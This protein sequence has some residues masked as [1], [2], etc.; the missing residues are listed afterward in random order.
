MKILLIDDDEDLR[1]AIGIALKAGGYTADAH[2]DCDTAAA[3]LASGAPRPDAILLDLSLVE[4]RSPEEFMAWLR[5]HGF[6]EVPVI[7]LT[8]RLDAA[9]QARTLGAAGH[10]TKPF[11]IEQLYAR[12]EALRQQWTIGVVTNGSP[13]VQREKTL[14]SGLD[15]FVEFV[16]VS[17]E[18]GAGKPDPRPFLRALDLAG[19]EP[20]DVLF[21]GDSLINDV[22]GSQAVGMT[23]A[24]VNRDR[25]ALPLD[26]PLPDIELPHLTGLLGHLGLPLLDGWVRPQYVAQPDV[27]MTTDGTYDCPGDPGVCRHGLV[28]SRTVTGAD[29]TSPEALAEADISDAADAAYDRD[30]VGARPFGGIESHQV[31]A[32]G[33][34]AVAGRAG[35]YVRWRVTTGAGAGGYVQSLVFPSSVGS[36]APVLVRFALDAGDDGPPLDDIDEIVRGIRPAG[37]TEAGTGGGVGSS[38]GPS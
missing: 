30:R 18:V 14:L 36:E 26:A 38:L 3:A 19:V 28:V 7:L 25:A 17:G 4:G 24:W 16:V 5:E 29:E 23:A 35:Y 12:L 20:R 34:V 11:V 27:V 22:G 37:D 13:E 1:F 9:E 32:S 33:Q 10:I 2:G 31:V 21:V 8:G 6:G 15:P